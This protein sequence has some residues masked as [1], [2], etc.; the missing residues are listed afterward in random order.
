MHCLHPL[1]EYPSTVEVLAG[2]QSSLR[3]EDSGILKLLN[4]MGNNQKTSKTL[5]CYSFNKGYMLNRANWVEEV[6]K[7][8]MKLPNMANS[9]VLA[10][11]DP[12]GTQ[13]L[14]FG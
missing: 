6:E 13:S 5:G 7:K 1:K 2:D 10:V 9:V 11:P 12:S 14:L 4:K 3:N 8:T